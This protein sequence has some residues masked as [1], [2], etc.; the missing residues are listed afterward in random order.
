ML[1]AGDAELVDMESYPEPRRRFLQRER[2]M[3]HVKLSA[4]AK[5]RLEAHS[6]KAGVSSDQL[7]K[8]WIEQRLNRRTG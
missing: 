3:V 6:R 5:R 7:A 4:S 2:D 1:D 8:Q